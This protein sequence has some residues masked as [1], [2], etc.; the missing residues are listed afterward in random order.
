MSGTLK[1]SEAAVL[2]LHAM[3]FI[4]KN[5]DNMAT[6]K[7]I[8]VFHNA[9][10]AHLSKVMQRLVRAGMVK[11]ARGPKGGFILGKNGEEITLLQI[12]ELFEGTLNMNNCLFETPVCGKKNCLFG[13]LIKD[14]N[15][16][17]RNYLKNT[18][19][20]DVA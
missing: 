3:V 5:R 12:Y 17:T 20:S 11:S 2:G 13:D 19:L 7:E 9:S 14:V 16:M 1:I 6:T 15:N 8:A 4:A 18:K 10:L